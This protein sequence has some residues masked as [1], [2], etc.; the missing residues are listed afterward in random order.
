I[1]DA[2]HDGIDELQHRNERL[3]SDNSR[4]E[5]DNAR[6]VADSKQLQ[7]VAGFAVGQLYG[8]LQMLRIR[9][10]AVHAGEDLARVTVPAASTRDEVRGFVTQLTR[11]ASDIAKSKGAESQAADS[12]LAVRIVDKRTMAE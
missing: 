8:M 6:L 10:L 1:T 7:Q 9:P 12:T 5:Q 2:L 4:L 11:D 3:I